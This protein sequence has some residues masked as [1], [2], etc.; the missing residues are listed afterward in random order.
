M[1]QLTGVPKCA[2]ERG[3]AVNNSHVCAWLVAAVLPRAMVQLSVQPI[4]PE[5]CAHGYSQTHPHHLLKI[6]LHS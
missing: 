3:G 1:C 4:R 5:P 6:M 2:R